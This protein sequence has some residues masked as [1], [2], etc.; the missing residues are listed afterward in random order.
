M[1]ADCGLREL[2]KTLHVTGTDLACKCAATRARVL[3]EL[4]DFDPGG[5]TQCLEYAVRFDHGRLYIDIFR[6]V[7]AF[8]FFRLRTGHLKQH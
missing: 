6:Y 2:Q 1:M 7:N 4:Q 8:S 5:V 3:Q